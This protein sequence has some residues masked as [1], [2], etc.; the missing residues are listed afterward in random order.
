MTDG[1]SPVCLGIKHPSVACDQIV[2]SHTVASLLMW[3][4]L[5]DGRTGLLFTIA[6]DP[7]QRSYSR[8]QVPLDL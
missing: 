4:A 7:R 3:G 2:I 6:I 1:Q 8:V 5:S